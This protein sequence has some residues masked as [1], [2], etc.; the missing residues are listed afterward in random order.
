MKI[1]IY[2][3]ENLITNKKYIGQSK[4]ITNR[5]SRHRVELRKGTHFNPYLQNSWNKYGEKSFKFYILEI[6]SSPNDL[7]NK[8]IF[9]IKKLDTIIPS[10]MNFNSGGL[11]VSPS[12]ETREKISKTLKRD[13]N[14]RRGIPRTK[15][16]KENISNATKGKNKGKMPW[17]KGIPFSSE[18]R[19]KISKTNKSKNISP[20]KK[21]WFVAGNKPW[22]KGLSPSKETREKISK[23]G[24]GRIVS[25]ETRKKQSIAAKNRHKR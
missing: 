2:C 21:F 9:W 5:W 10:G 1:G 18:T 4:N 6:V 14:P 20:P 3:I 12:E 17:N 8:E 23:A 11:Y 15:K 7:N 19:K 16:E 24:I 25:D 13:D 22:N